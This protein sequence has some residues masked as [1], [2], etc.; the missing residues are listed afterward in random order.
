MWKFSGIMVM[1]NIS[2]GGW[3]AKVVHLSKLIECV[4]KICAIS[5]NV[6]FA[7][8]EKLQQIELCLMICMLNV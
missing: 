6:Y 8:K 7:L 1:F 3:V 2:I 4:L 5:L